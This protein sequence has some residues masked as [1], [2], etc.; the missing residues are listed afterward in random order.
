MDNNVLIVAG[1]V[2][3]VIFVALRAFGGNRRPKPQSFRCG[4]CS[5]SSQHTPRTIEAWRR[6]KTKFFCNACHAEWLRNRPDEAR[7]EPA[8]HSGCL[9][10]IVLAVVIPSV[11]S[12]AYLSR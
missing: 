2:V 4:R 12:I 6:G 1:L 10:M 11:A 3:A 5:T 8:G 9:G 7:H